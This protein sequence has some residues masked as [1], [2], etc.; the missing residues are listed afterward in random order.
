MGKSWPEW[1]LF[2][3]ERENNTASSNTSIAV[4]K[5]TYE[6]LDDLVEDSDTVSKAEIVEDLVYDAWKSRI[7]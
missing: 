4:D 6:R 3:S 7:K 2:P 1:M 5:V